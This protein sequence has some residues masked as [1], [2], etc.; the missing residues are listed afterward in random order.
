M[1]K[2]ASTK[3]PAATK[4][5]ARSVKFTE[6]AMHGLMRLRPTTG[7][8]TAGLTITGFE[9]MVKRSR[10]GLPVWSGALHV[11]PATLERRM[12]KMSAFDALESD[13]LLTVEQVLKRGMDVFEDA[14]EL[15]AWLERKH[16]LLENKRP[17]DLLGST[18]G[19]GLVMMELGRIEHGVY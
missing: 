5:A 3:K 1:G 15:G 4:K 14:D 10:V 11:S 12:E 2:T 18:A 19:I 16:R 9:K 17:M 7:S 6:R 13:R 8:K